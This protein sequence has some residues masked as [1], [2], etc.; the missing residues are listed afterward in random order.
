[1]ADIE[2]DALFHTDLGSHIFLFHVLLRK[3]FSL[4]WL[5]LFDKGNGGINPF[6][7]SWN[8]FSKFIFRILFQILRSNGK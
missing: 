8:N 6:D 4:F 1:M 2:R 3:A 5:V 7:V